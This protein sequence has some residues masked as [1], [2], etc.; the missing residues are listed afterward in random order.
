MEGEKPR[1]EARLKRVMT[2]KPR[3]LSNVYLLISFPDFRQAEEEKSKCW[4]GLV[5]CNGVTAHQ[6]A[7]C[8]TSDSEA[9]EGT[10]L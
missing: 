5:C 6:E 3:I 4:P 8:G 9:P 1:K 7:S 2:I 10:C